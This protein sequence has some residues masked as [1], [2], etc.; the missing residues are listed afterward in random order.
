MQ[1]LNYAFQHLAERMLPMELT[2]RVESFRLDFRTILPMEEERKRTNP[3]W[4]FAR[5]GRRKM[6]VEQPGERRERGSEA[7]SGGRG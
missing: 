5:P 3:G 4:H 1:S 6:R 7:G 2:R